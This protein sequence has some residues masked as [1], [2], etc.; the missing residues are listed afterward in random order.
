MI[1]FQNHCR[2]IDVQDIQG[3]FVGWPNPPRA[4]THLKILRNSSLVIV[5]RNES[6]LVVGFITALT[7]FILSASIPLLEVLPEY[8]GQGLGQELMARML[9]ELDGLYMID[10]SCDSSLTEFYQKHGFRKAQAMI[11]R[12]YDHQ[13]GRSQKPQSKSID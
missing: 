10:L 13:S 12:H 7:D 3:F 4:E 2:D 6:G 9:K 11:Q 1:C 8:Q 5:A